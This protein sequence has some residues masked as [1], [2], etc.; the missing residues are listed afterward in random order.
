MANDGSGDEDK[1]FDCIR[2]GGDSP[3]RYEVR[4]LGNL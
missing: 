3:A 4:P 1:V 2:Q